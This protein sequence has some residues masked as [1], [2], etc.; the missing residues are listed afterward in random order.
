MTAEEALVHF[1]SNALQK[2]W[3]D[4]YV[5]IV[6]TKRGKRRFLEDLSHTLERRF[7]PTKSLLD[8]PEEVW[9]SQAFSFRQPSGFGREEE[10]MRSAFGIRD[11]SSLIID[12]TGNYGIYQPE[13]MI[14]DIE[15]YSCLTNG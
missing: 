5:S 15:Y 7:D 2:R 12:K 10:S 14:D 6:P 13:D 1:L 11:D 3:R 9:R 4:R 8:F